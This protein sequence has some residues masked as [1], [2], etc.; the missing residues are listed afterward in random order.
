MELDKLDDQT[1]E[2]MIECLGPIE[3]RQIIWHI[4]SLEKENDR[5]NDKIDMLEHNIAQL[6]EM[7]AELE[8]LWYDFDRSDD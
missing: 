7:Y 1:K 3:A 2:G 4:E 6:E 5:L 8:D